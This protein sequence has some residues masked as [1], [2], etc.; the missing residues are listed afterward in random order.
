MNDTPIEREYKARDDTAAVRPLSACLGVL[1]A[2]RLGV[3]DGL[4]AGPAWTGAARAQD[5]IH[6][7]TLSEASDQIQR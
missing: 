7:L 6:Q 4:L 3:L 2:L 5:Y 1:V